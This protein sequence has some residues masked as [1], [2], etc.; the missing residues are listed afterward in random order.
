MIALLAALALLQEDESGFLGL[1]EADIGHHGELVDIALSGIVDAEMY[2][3]NKV[4]PGMLMHDHRPLWNGRGTFFLDVSVGDHL[5][6]MVMARADH[7]LD[8]HYEEELDLRLDEA[9]LRWTESGD[10]WSAS[11]QAGK[12]GTPI[13]NFVPRHDSMHNPLVR[14]PMVYDHITTMGDNAAP[15]PNDVFI[16]RR[17]GP[18]LKDRW[19]SMIWGP[20]YG[21]GLMLFGDAGRFSAR[22]AYTNTAACERPPE[23][24]WHGDDLKDMG[25]H[26]RLGWNPFIGFKIGLNATYGPYLRNRAD[27]SMPAGLHRQDY[28]QKLVGIDLEYSI[29]HLILF[30]EA[31]ATEWEAPRINGDLRAVSYYVEAKYKIVPGVYVAARWNQILFNQIPTSQGSRT[32]DRDAYRAEFGVGWFIEQ[33]L[34][35][36]AQVEGNVLRGPH[37]PR[38]NMLSVSISMSW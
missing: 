6:G 8:A 30:G 10:G 28:A 17:D 26:S 35:V 5:F 2:L 19:V 29:G 21:R 15:P 18:D 31:Y 37:D 33:N 32:W 14:A 7:G 23:W 3:Y 38:D 16:T 24:D 12:F 22:V 36:K 20:V 27:A 1:H 11:L 13:G 25:W 34:L 4:N 9:W